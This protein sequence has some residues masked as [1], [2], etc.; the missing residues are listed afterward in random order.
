MLFRSEGEK[1]L[2]TLALVYG[3]SVVAKYTKRHLPNY[4]VFD[5][6]RNFGPGAGTLIARFK[7][8]DIA[9]AICEDIWQD[10]GVV[11]EIAARKPGLVL[12]AN[13]SP[14]ERKKDDRRLALV[15]K[16]AREFASPLVY[17]NQVGAQDDL[18]FDG[19]SVIVESEGKVLARAPQ[20]ESDIFITDVDVLTA[21]S[22]PDIELKGTL[23]I[24]RVDVKP[25]LAE[26]L[27]DEDEMWTALVVG[28][29]DYID[30]KSTR[31]NSSHRT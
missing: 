1:P 4:G 19:D 17:V 7:G 27:S 14:Y 3:G 13:A 23:R 2:N 21:T 24:P 9:V 25:L 10:S 20:F 30:R 8:V 15:Q 12:V 18:V 16:R 22:K 26:R 29:R 11:P 31:L 28:L 6:F 5:E